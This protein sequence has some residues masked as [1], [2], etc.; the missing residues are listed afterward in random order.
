MGR[1]GFLPLSG[2]VLGFRAMPTLAT[3]GESSVKG[4]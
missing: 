4:E 3:P 1:F 2:G